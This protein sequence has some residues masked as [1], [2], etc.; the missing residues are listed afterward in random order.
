L[1]TLQGNDFIGFAV[2]LTRR[3][4]AGAEADATHEKRDD[5]MVEEWDIVVEENDKAT[6]MCLPYCFVY[7]LVL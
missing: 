7:I 3:R 4:A 6:A 2:Q 5:V 1:G